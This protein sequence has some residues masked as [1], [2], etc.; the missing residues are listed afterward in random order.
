[1][2][3]LALVIILL[4]LLFL[5]FFEQSNQRIV[6]YVYLGI[7]FLLVAMAALRPL[8]IDKDSH[9]YISYF[10]GR[11]IG[12][13]G[14]EYSFQLLVS[15]IRSLSTEVRWLFVTYALLSIPLFIT[16]VAKFSTT[17]L[18]S[19]GV[20]ISNLY[21]LQNLTQIRVAVSV[22]FFLW[23]LY[24]IYRQQK[25]Y[26]FLCI[27][28]A[29]F[30]H[31]SAL[32]YLFG[33]FLT[34]RDIGKKENI[35]LLAIPVVTFAL[36]FGGT[37]ILELIPLP[38]IQERVKQYDTMSKSGII[39]GEGINYFNIPYLSKLVVYYLILWKYSL[40]KLKVPYIS[41]IIRTYGAS[42]FFYILLSFLPIM[43]SRV[44]E[45]FGV[46]ECLLIPALI[47]G[48]Y[49][50]IVGKTLVFLHIFALFF[51]NIFYLQLLKL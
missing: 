36:S 35:L 10:F 31:Y 23:G 39:G 27:L 8:G 13:L 17:P 11:G 14:V 20:W 41:L 1:M 15:T 29:I 50:R 40:I 42:I 12:G 18:L 32:F 5:S 25:K 34:N 46:V 28:A 45:L 2:F 6:A 47:Y 51:I 49:P 26:Y 19:L 43:A 3:I 33:L 7:A 44:S 22:A 16:V 38:Y 48:I 24:F 4:T 30:F 37:S 9:T 21:I